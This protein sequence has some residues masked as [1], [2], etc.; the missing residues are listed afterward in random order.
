MGAQWKGLYFRGRDRPGAG[1]I[2]PPTPTLRHNAEK[3]TAPRDHEHSPIMPRRPSSDVWQRWCWRQWRDLVR[4]RRCRWGRS[5]YYTPVAMTS[6]LHD[7][8]VSLSPSTPTAPRNSHALCLR[9]SPTRPSPL[10]SST[11][12]AAKAGEPG[13]TG[14]FVQLSF[15]SCFTRAYPTSQPTAAPRTATNTVATLARA[16]RREPS[17]PQT[18]KPTRQ[19]EAL[20]VE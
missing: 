1:K 2:G 6:H 20:M 8:P 16:A 11:T 3:P 14:A 17:P 7:A 19:A 5:T 15:L 13:T 4:H 9:C 10:T 12:P 18:T